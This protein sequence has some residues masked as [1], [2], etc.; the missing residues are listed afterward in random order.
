MVTNTQVDEVGQRHLAT[1]SEVRKSE[2]KVFGRKASVWADKQI[3]L[4]RR[5]L[6]TL[7]M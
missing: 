4:K 5:K 1:D 6:Q 3:S 7:E 2:H